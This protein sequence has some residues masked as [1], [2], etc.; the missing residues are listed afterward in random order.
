[1]CYVSFQRDAP[2][3][4]GDTLDL[5]VARTLCENAL[6]GCPMFLKQDEFAE[7]SVES[8]VEECALDVAVGIQ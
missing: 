5:D 4:A 6:Q 8:F 2:A 1:M 3:D 7:I